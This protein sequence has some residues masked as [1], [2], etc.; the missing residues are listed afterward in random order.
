MTPEKLGIDEDAFYADLVFTAVNGLTS[1]LEM[2][3]YGEGSVQEL[4]KEYNIEIPDSEFETGWDLAT[5]L[6]AAHYAGEEAYDLYGTE[7]AILLRTVGL[8]LFDDLSTVS[9][10]IFFKAANTIFAYFGTDSIIKD[11]TKYATG[12]LGPVTVGEYLLLAIA[13]PILYEFAY[14]SDGVNDNTGELEGYGTE[15][16]TFANISDKVMN[17]IEK[18]ILYLNMI[19][20]IAS[21]IFK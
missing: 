21:K 13:S 12:V 20:N 15:T 7:V 8:I 17:F 6:V 14:D 10:E 16:E 18:V 11:L 5:E 2:P 9:D 19:L 1:I 3:L 4:A